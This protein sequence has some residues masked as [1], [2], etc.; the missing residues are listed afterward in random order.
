[1]NSTSMKAPYGRPSRRWFNFHLIYQLPRGIV[2][3]DEEVMPGIKLYEQSINLEILETIKV[4]THQD[5][6]PKRIV[7]M[8]SLIQITKQG[9]FTECVSLSIRNILHEFK[10]KLLGT[11][12]S[13][14]DP[15]RVHKKGT[16]LVCIVPNQREARSPPAF[17]CLLPCND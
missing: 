14:G 13:R 9:V 1:M 8:T 4:K 6:D 2:L 5:I 15:Q 11:L 7:I 10:H 12:R 3:T 16:I 17:Y